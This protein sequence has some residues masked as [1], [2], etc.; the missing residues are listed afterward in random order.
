VTPGEVVTINGNLS[1]WAGQYNFTKASGYLNGNYGGF[2]IDIGQDIFNNQTATWQVAYL[3]DAPVPG[4]KMGPIKANLIEELWA[5]D[6]AGPTGALASPSNAAAFQLA[7]WEI[8]N[9]TP[10][11]SGTYVIGRQG[12][13]FSATDSD[14]NTIP[15]ANTWLAA[16]DP[17]GNGTKANLI[18]LT[19][20]QFQDYVVQAPATATPAPSGLVLGGMA[21]V[22]GALAAGWRRLRRHVGRLPA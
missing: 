14:P 8:I 22:S 4:L 7:I 10:N 19:S 12:D 1:G 9:G 11:S 20:T 2:C 5:N 13:T 17:S 16:L 18:A 15:T 21:A 3:K 6:Y